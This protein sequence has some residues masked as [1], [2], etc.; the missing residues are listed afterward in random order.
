MQKQRKAAQHKQ[1]LM[2][3]VIVRLLEFSFGGALR[4]VVFHTLNGGRRAP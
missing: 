1:S 4:C 3:V 2:A